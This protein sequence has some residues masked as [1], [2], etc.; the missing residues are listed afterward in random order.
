MHAAK[1]IRPTAIRLPRT[2]RQ[3]IDQR[4]AAT[5][6]TEHQQIRAALMLYFKCLDA[7]QLAS[8]AVTVAESTLVH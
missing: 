6:Q 1:R 2:L 7:A 5:G 8:S 4:T 3:Q